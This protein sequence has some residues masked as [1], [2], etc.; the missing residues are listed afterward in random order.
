MGARAN[1]PVFDARE[2]RV[3]EEY[4]LCQPWSIVGAVAVLL[5]DVPVLD[6]VG[7]DLASGVRTIAIE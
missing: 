4:T 6:E 3:D 7:V 2:D 5:I 1:I